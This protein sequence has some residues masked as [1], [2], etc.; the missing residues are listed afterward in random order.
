MTVLVHRPRTASEPWQTVSGQTPAH[1]PTRHPP[2]QPIEP[3]KR[4]VRKHKTR[5]P[6]SFVLVAK[7]SQRLLGSVCSFREASGGDLEGPRIF[8]KFAARAH[9]GTSAPQQR[10]PAPGRL[11]REAAQP[12]PPPP[13]IL[14]TGPNRWHASCAPSGGASTRPCLRK[15]VRERESKRVGGGGGG[16]TAGS[17]VSD[18]TGPPQQRR[19]NI[20]SGSCTNL[21][22]VI[23][24]FL[25][26]CP[27]DSTSA[28]EPSELSVHGGYICG[29]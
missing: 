14:S 17:Q 16:R 12:P 18:S 15:R 26:E 24:M 2:K 1:R 27:P 8:P 6:R 21:R 29:V 4:V 11:F 20:C 25:G 5:L 28:V 9:R 7:N 19:F 3:S 13:P 10:P 22:S 23:E